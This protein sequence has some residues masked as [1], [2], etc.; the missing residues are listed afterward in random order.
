MRKLWKHRNAR[1]YIIGQCF[2]LFGDTA[3]F[4]AMAIWVKELTGSNGAAGFVF[5]AF[6]VAALL[7][8]L[9]GMVVD[10]LPRRPLLLWSNLA[11]AA[12]VLLLLFVHG[13][14]SSGSSTSWPSCTASSTRSS[15]PAS[16]RC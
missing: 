1:R 4:L 14:A 7:S 2:S 5:F 10:R 11:G 16:R 6:A 12:V 13:R 8:P 15:A 9:A 3:L